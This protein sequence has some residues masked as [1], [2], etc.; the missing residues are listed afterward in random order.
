L[1]LYD[2]VDPFW[3]KPVKTLNKHS[4]LGNNLNSQHSNIVLNPI[5]F[6]IFLEYDFDPLVQ[7]GTLDT[8]TILLL[9]HGFLF[10]IFGAP[11]Q[12]IFLSNINPPLKIPVMVL[13]K[14]RNQLYLG[15]I[16]GVDELHVDVVADGENW[17]RVSIQKLYFVFSQLGVD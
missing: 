6:A 10:P 17:Q 1:H 11:I 5:N 7:I 3:L 9:H 12:D 13:F 8:I 16:K 2:L 15:F 14:R 4:I